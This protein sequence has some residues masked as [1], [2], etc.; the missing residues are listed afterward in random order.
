[1]LLRR[2]CAVWKIHAR[3]PRPMNYSSA[4]PLVGRHACPH[5]VDADSAGALQTLLLIGGT[6]L[7]IETLSQSV[8]SSIQ[9]SLADK[10]GVRSCPTR[11]NH[12]SVES[13]PRSASASSTARRRRPPTISPKNS[14]PPSQPTPP[15]TPPRRHKPLSEALL[16]ALALQPAPC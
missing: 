13:S 9:V 3:G 14:E 6:S 12:K 15:I 16:K 7:R 5:R 11:L 8:R 10:D 1:M 2:S 4:I